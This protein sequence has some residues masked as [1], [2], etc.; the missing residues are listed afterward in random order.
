MSEKSNFKLVKD[1]FTEENTMQ[2]LME[3]D[4]VL[5]VIDYNQI[6][7]LLYRYS[8]VNDPECIEFLNTIK[9]IFEDWKIE[10]SRSVLVDDVGT[11]V[12]KCFA[13][14]LGKNVIAYEFYYCHKSKD[15]FP[16][17]I[18]YAREFAIYTEMKD[19]RLVDFGVC[20]AFLE[21]DE[22]SLIEK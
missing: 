12:T 18:V 19:N 7:K 2:F 15:G 9:N 1:V 6:E 20:N 17:R 14:F 11:R 21:K 8:I 16:S 13:C 5:K 3:L 10:G 22:V 4:L